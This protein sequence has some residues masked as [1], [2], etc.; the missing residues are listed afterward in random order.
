MFVENLVA[1]LNLYKIR[2]EQ[3]G[4]VDRTSYELVKD[5]D[6][7]GN[8]WLLRLFDDEGRELLIW[9]GFSSWRTASALPG[10]KKRPALYFSVRNNRDRFE[11]YVRTS[12]S[13]IGG[14]REVVIEPG[15]PSVIYAA[16]ST[17]KSGGISDSADYI[18]EQI[19]RSFVRGEIPV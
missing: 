14:L 18:A 5:G 11:P 9:L 13:Q 8:M 3:V 16:F 19:G 4:D 7:T 15:M 17:L 6:A 2:V 1:A 10:G 12:E